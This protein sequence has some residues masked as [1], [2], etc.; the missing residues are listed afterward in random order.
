MLSL[1]SVLETKTLKSQHRSIVFQRNRP[2]AVR[3]HS[4]YLPFNWWNADIRLAELPKTG[5]SGHSPVTRKALEGSRMEGRSSKP[6]SVPTAAVFLS[7]ASEDAEAAE[8]I[9]AAP[10]AAGIEVS[11]WL[12]NRRV[13]ER[14][15]F[16]DE[17]AAE[18]R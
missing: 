3:L 1:P 18:S 10:R 14:H 13:L 7:Y 2:E 6:A 5:T 11:K 9:A 4:R 17:E 16:R 15:T 8:R 12:L